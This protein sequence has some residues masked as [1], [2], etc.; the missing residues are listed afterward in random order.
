MTNSAGKS[1][2]D[3]VVEAIALHGR[4][5]WV[6]YVPMNTIRLIDKKYFLFY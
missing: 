5:N 6:A 2:E 1:P 4:P 3:Q